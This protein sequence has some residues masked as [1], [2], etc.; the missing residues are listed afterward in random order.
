MLH[1]NLINQRCI[2]TALWYSVQFLKKKP[3][4]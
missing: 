4:V 3:C 1:V 2:W